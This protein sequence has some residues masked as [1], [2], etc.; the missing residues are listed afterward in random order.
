MDLPILIRG[1]EIEVDINMKRNTIQELISILKS[2]HW[3]IS[4]LNK[5]FKELLCE[6]RLE[7]IIK[8][9][10]E[11][12]EEKWIDII[13]NRIL[14]LYGC[15]ISTKYMCIYLVAYCKNKKPDDPIYKSVK[16][17]FYERKLK[18][19]YFTIHKIID[20]GISDGTY[21]GIIDDQGT[22][23]D[24][25]YFK[26]LIYI[27]EDDILNN[28]INAYKDKA[29]D[30]IDLKK[31]E[32]LYSNRFCIKNYIDN[33]SIDISANS[34]RQ[35]NI[36]KDGKIRRVFNLEKYSVTEI[37]FKYLKKRLDEVFKI[38][39]SDRNKIMRSVFNLI[40]NMNC[41]DDY[42]IYRFDIKNFFDTVNLN[43][44]LKK[45]IIKSDLKQYEKDILINLSCIYK[46]C[47]AG[48]PTSN[49]LIEIAGMEFDKKIKCNLKEDGLIFYSRYVDDGLIIFNRNV[50]K[51][52]IYNK[53]VHILKSSFSIKMKFNRDKE[54]YLNK[55]SLKESFNYLGYMFYKNRNNKFEFGI[56]EEKIKKYTLKIEQIVDSYML[57]RDIELFRQR[58]KYFISRTVFYNNNNS[59]YS[60]HG[61]WDV[62][63]ISENY[64]LLRKYIEKDMITHKT[65]NFL[66]DSIIIQV[67][68]K[69]HGD[70]PYFLKNKGKDLYSIQNS[71]VKNKSIVFHPNIG[72]SQDHLANHIHKL[73][74]CED[75]SKK[76]YRECVKIYCNLIKLNE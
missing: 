54:K 58:L 68:R 66:K 23:V 49:A 24:E 18:H 51:D 32:K 67:N 75:L 63:G 65:R 62:L 57:N 73:N 41:L 47:F 35:M 69:L 76:S 14:E 44:I 31:I 20:S 64:C 25:T 50:P 12:S 28:I 40:E 59:R 4:K 5:R 53:L 16:E 9:L 6:Y 2:L 10:S 8:K 52:L 17:F 30:E 13:K 11:S 71:I 29:E 70:I 36:K 56:D 45:Y 60:S 48:L 34:I 37:A 72:W 46:Y 61:K 19:S 15:E 26:N 55:Q 38:K 33:S 74:P 1:R 3:D 43:E 42:T 39:Y 27:K 21:L 22:I 7:K